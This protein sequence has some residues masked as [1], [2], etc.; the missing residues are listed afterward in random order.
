MK[1]AKQMN[2]FGAVCVVVGSIIGS[3]IFAAPSIVAQFSPSLF[4]TA[5]IWIVGTIMCLCGGQ[6]Y[7]RLAQ[8]FPHSG[9]Q[10]VFIRESFNPSIAAVYG[11]ISF[12]VMCP[13][14]I[15][16]SSLFFGE[17]LRFLAPN[18]ST[19][20]IKMIGLFLAL[21]FTFL[22]HRGIEL[23]G[24]FQSVLVVLLVAVLFLVTASSYAK[25]MPSEIP[26]SHDSFRSGS[27]TQGLWALA[28]V[29]W[30]FEGFNAATFLTGEI[31][32]GAQRS[33]KIV[34]LALAIVI[35]S[36]FAFINA[37]HRYIP[38]ENLIHSPNVGTTLAS[39]SLG[40]YGGLVVFILT[41]LT[42]ASAL[43]TSIMIGPRITSRLALDGLCW[44]R[45]SRTHARYRSPSFALWSQMA[46]VSV[47]LLAG[48]FEMLISFFI[49]VNWLFYGITA[50]GYHNLARNRNIHHSF[51]DKIS[52][53]LFLSGVWTLLTFQVVSQP[54]LTA[55]GLAFV[56][57][58]YGILRYLSGKQ[59]IKGLSKGEISEPKTAAHL[60]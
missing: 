51:W 46:L 10:Y 40:S 19:F 33:I 50:M 21:L 45:L 3:G 26:V 30:T 17:Q 11:W 7:G 16:G 2:S 23:A 25:L 6:I 57:A 31:K 55:A 36:Y 54:R 35:I 37:V 20:E 13:L 14:M 49:I 56:S 27:L 15:A 60:I 48:S 39:L 28:I 44:E 24:R 32:N 42:I 58:L 38:Y 34:F 22:N 9:G 52:I 8:H 29:L 1:S 5:A 4:I 12:L 43:H 41:C 18:I 53:L 59:V 47:F